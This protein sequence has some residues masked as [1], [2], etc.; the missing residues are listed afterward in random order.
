MPDK[1]ASWEK[2]AQVAAEAKAAKQKAKDNGEEVPKV[3]I[4]KKK[5]TGGLVFEPTKGLWD[6][7]IL[8]MDFNSLYPSII[9]EYD[10]DFST[11]DWTVE[12][13]S[14]RSCRLLL[15]LTT[16]FDRSLMTLRRCRSVRHARENRKEF[17]LSSLPPS[18][19]VVVTSRI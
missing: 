2:K 1:I 3:A 10:I 14:T 9:Q 15:V 13:V 12:G 19:P 5:F 8:V 11:I 6:R 4:S 7:Y 18:S 16:A 17:F